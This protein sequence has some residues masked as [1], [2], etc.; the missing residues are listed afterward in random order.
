MVGTY[1]G[2]DAIEGLEV[3]VDGVQC[4]GDTN[5]E[6]VSYSENEYSAQIGAEYPLQR[7]A[8]GYV[9]QFKYYYRV[10]DLTG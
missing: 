4:D 8:S 6:T 3:Y 9:D 2:S 10:L 1:D 7:R 5:T